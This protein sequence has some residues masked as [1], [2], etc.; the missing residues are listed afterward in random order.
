MSAFQVATT[1]L[2][3]IAYLGYGSSD[4]EVVVLSHGFPY[5]VRSYADVAPILA[6][7]GLRVIVPWLRGY[8]PT[9]FRD[10]A[11]MRSGQ[12]AA[13]GRDLVDLLDALG[14]EN[15]VVG[16]YDWGGRASCV[17]AALHPER[18]RGLVTVDGYNIQ[19]IDQQTAPAAPHAEKNMW[20]QQYFQSDR[21]RAGL[22][23]NRRELCR[24]LWN[25]WSPSWA[26][27]DDAFEASADSL[28]NPD[29]VDVVIHSYRHRRRAAAGDTRYDD[30]ERALAAT[31]A[32]TVPAV[33]L[34]GRD[35]GMGFSDPEDDR[36]LFVGGFEGRVLDGVG[37][38]PPQEAPAAFADAVLSLSD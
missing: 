17:A 13:L 29:F 34:S 14:I 8:G 35:K 28:N 9:R 23:M 7:R 2:L 10:P 6:E 33:V 1:P 5:D 21:G 11:I 16:G 20:Y 22:V 32:I 24:L 12:Q 26:G 4:G 19:D 15:A 38:N 37:H 3:D 30:D 36:K 18:I 25:D 31:P 27:A